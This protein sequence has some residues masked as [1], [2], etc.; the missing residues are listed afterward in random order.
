MPGTVVRGGYGIFSALNQGSTYY[1][2]RVENGIYQLNYNYS[3]CGATNIISASNTKPTASCA[4]VP[5]AGTQLVYPNVPFTPT[6]PSISGALK[7][8]GSNTPVVQTVNAPP[9]YSFHGLDPNFVPPYTHEADF[10]VEQ[11]LPGKMSLSVG[12]VG[13]RGM[14]LPVFVDAN[15]IGQTPHGI[16]TY[17]VLNSSNAVTQVLTVP[18]YLPSDRRNT[19]LATFN[20]GFSAANTWYNSLAATLRR[21]FANGLETILNYTWAKST[22][23]SA[24]NGANG[25]FYGGD[26]PLDPNNIRAENGLSDVDVRNRFT[27]TMV[28]Q[29]HLFE[30][31]KIVK[32]VLD[33]FIFSGS[34]IASAGQPIYLGMS[35]TVYSGS[36]SATSYGD[37]G[38]IYGGAISS[39]SGS[40]T[41]G[42]PPQIQRN[43]IIGPGFND[44]DFRL[45]RNIPLWEK[46]YL[47]FSADAFNLLN[48]RIVTGVNGT[49]S[50]YA[51]ASGSATSA[52]ST[53]AGTATAGTVPGGST[54]QGCISPYSGTGL[55]A[56]GAVSS[57][58]NGL[59]TARQMQFSAKLFF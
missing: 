49:Y 18:V 45:S 13:T 42:R 7:P 28:Y 41:T 20:T 4:A 38:G 10:S 59:Y 35:G 6:G 2:D 53:A 14:R 16:R 32:H 50:Q 15:L 47:Q 12:Y 30:S 24:V 3:A 5:A 46:T 58:G 31:S 9:A 57:T 27:L 34:E 44:F 48:H 25:T 54:L 33:D 1:A 56:F 26:A 39:G 29:P 36:T 21:P 52:C 8:T 51:A 19:A 11:S 55:S 23:T 43:S 37:D 22:D 17:D 40:P